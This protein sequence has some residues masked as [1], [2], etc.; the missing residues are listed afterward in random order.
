MGSIYE[1]YTWNY[2]LPSVPNKKKLP[3]YSDEQNEIGNTANSDA[4]LGSDQNQSIK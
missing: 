3:G 2:S 4:H 1:G